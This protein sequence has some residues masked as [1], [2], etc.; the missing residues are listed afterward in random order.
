MQG[1]AVEIWKLLQSLEMTQE[2]TNSSSSHSIQGLAINEEGVI[3]P[4]CL[5]HT[6]V[7][8]KVFKKCKWARIVALKAGPYTSSIKIP[9][10]LIRKANL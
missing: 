5:E 8:R 3:P 6:D 10:K 9:R 7:M 1:R 4:K 2:K